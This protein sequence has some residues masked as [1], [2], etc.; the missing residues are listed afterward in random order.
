MQGIS[1]SMESILRSCSKVHSETAWFGASLSHLTE[2]SL[3]PDSF[4]HGL[5]GN[6]IREGQL[7][8]W[9]TPSLRDRNCVP[10]YFKSPG[11]SF[12]VAANTDILPKATK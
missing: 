9:L 5:H 12:V 2:V 10:G 1:L 11:Q 6:L 4:A 3:R 8:N 7:M